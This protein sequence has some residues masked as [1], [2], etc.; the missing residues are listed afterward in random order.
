MSPDSAVA[1]I[2]MPMSIVPAPAY[3]TLLND[4]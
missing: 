3:R 2:I 4:F 1:A